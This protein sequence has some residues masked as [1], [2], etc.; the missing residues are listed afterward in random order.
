MITKPEYLAHAKYLLE[1][2]FSIKRVSDI[3]GLARATLYRNFKEVINSRRKCEYGTPYCK[4]YVEVQFE[5]AQGKLTS[6]IV[7][8][9]QVDVLRQ[10]YRDNLKEKVIHSV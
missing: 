7:C 10:I 6:Q 3:T 4:N 2:N 9:T 1:H 8:T 5:N